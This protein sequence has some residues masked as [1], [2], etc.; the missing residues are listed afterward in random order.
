MSNVDI[1][2][3]VATKSGLITPIVKNTPYLSVDEISDT[4]KVLHIQYNLCKMAILKRTK[5][6]FQDQLS[7]KA[8]QK[9]CRAFRNTF[10]H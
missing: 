2:V 6:L 9:Y 7:L 3:A 10:D 4:V 5:N 8:G 1:S